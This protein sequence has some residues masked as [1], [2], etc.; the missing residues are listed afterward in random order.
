[1]RADRAVDAAKRVVDLMAA[2]YQ[3]CDVVVVFDGTDGSDDLEDQVKWHVEVKVYF[4]G[5][6][7]ALPCGCESQDLEDV[8]DSSVQ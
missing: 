3:I 5:G 7:P 4:E 6:K 8:P 1:M 2:K